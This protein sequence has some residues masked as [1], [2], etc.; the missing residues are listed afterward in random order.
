MAKL[1][2]VLD[3][4]GRLGTISAY[5]RKDI[6]GIILRAPGGASREKIKNSPSFE[7]T[8]EI[9]KE[10]GGRS[11]AS[12]LIMQAMWPLKPLAD[13]NIAGPLNKLI[14]PLQELDTVNLKGK[15]D[16][17]F[18][19][20][21]GL[22][23]GFQF[24]KKNPFDSIVRSQVSFTLDR[25][26]LSAAVSIPKLVP[27]INFVVPP[28]NYPL[29]SLV[30]RVNPVPNLS[31]KGARYET[32]NDE[33]K[34]LSMIEPETPWYPVQKGSDAVVFE[35]ILEAADPGILKDDFVLVM[36][37]G[38]RFGTIGPDGE[39]Q[40]VKYAGAAKILAVR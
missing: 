7:R 32:V 17:F 8:R 2:S 4:T 27:G 14:K 25:E 30:V 3:F 34:K 39:V 36:G 33:F 10:F 22:L 28:V 21:P 20:A 37:I 35:N 11:R 38:I 13:Y 19:K 12:G 31:L 15:R 26:Q 5:K 23:E 24:N 29:F 18:T 9:N 40:Q 6:D 16:I 1:K